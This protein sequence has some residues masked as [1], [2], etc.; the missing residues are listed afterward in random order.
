[1]KG[2]DR[3]PAD[4]FAAASCCV[5]NLSLRIGAEPDRSARLTDPTTQIGVLPVKK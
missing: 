3:E 5:D 2:A 4:A 1:M